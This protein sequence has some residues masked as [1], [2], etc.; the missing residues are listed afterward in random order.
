MRCSQRKF[1][2]ITALS[3]Q[4]V[5]WLKVT[6]KAFADLSYTNSDTF[7]FTSTNTTLMR[8]ASLTLWYYRS[9]KTV[10]CPLQFVALAQVSKVLR[11]NFSG[12]W[13][14]TVDHAKSRL[15]EIAGFKPSSNPINIARK[16]PCQCLTSAQSWNPSQT[17]LDTKQIKQILPPHIWDKKLCSTILHLL[18]RRLQSQSLPTKEGNIL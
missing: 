14:W 8:S 4:T 16:L 7:W 18:L 6:W 3:G 17:T 2:G 15:H 1:R 13:D 12:C 9:R 11:S 10:Y 5:G